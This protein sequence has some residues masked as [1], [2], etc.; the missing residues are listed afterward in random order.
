MTT[1]GILVIVAR[2]FYLDDL[3]AL[4]GISVATARKYRSAG[5][6]R[7]PEPDGTDSEKGHARPWWSEST[8]RQWVDDRPGSGWWGSDPRRHARA[9]RS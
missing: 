8:A 9:A 6:A 5:W 1:C 4:A 3:A 7:F 2:K